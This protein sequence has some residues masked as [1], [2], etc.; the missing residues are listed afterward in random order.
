M[1][2]AAV[3]AVGR[4]DQLYARHLNAMPVSCCP[5]MPAPIS[6]SWMLSLGERGGAVCASRGFK[7]GAVAA[8]AAAWMNFLRSSIVKRV[9]LSP[10]SFRVTVWHARREA[11]PRVTAFLRP[12]PRKPK[13]LPTIHLWIPEPNGYQRRMM[14]IRAS[15]DLKERVKPRCPTRSRNLNPRLDI[16]VSEHGFT[17]LWRTSEAVASSSEHL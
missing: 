1:G 16:R 3:I 6:A 15:V 9:S 5:W 17:V 8:R 2:Q 12:G 14:T 7:C 13:Q 10:L 11:T 4:G